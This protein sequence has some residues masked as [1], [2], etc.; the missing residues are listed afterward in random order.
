MAKPKISLIVAAGGLSKRFF[1]D[2]KKQFVLLD[3]IPLIN[4]CLNRFH[5]IDFIDEIIVAAPKDELKNTKMLIKKYGYNK[6]T[7]VT[8]GGKERRD[9]VYN[10]FKKLQADTDIVIIHDAARPL[11]TENIIKKTVQSC[12]KHGASISAVPI[13]DTVKKIKSS[14]LIDKT[15]AREKLW[16]AQTPQVFRYDILKIV[17]NN[18][19]SNKISVTDESQL[20]EQ[21]GFKVKI[22]RGSEFNIKITTAVDLQYA[23]FLIQNGLVK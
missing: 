22:T 10:G 4:H 1:S 11:V 21:N 8:Q 3:G 15:I 16:R 14:R 12:I 17:Y 2:T 9:S 6:V 19:K 13:G 5:S 7:H 23:E 20:A 18:N